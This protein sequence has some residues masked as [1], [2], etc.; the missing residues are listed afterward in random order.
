MKKY[1][2]ICF[3]AALAFAGCDNDE[4]KAPAVS[5]DA[6][7]TF[8]DTRDGQVYPYAKYGDLEWMTINLR[9]KPG[10][11][12]CLPELV[13]QDDYDDPKN[14]EYY[15]EFG[16][17]YSYEAAEAAVPEGW[18]IPTDEDW[19]KLETVF[20][21][22]RSELGRKGERGTYTG[23]LMLQGDSGSGFNFGLGGYAI[24][25]SASTSLQ[26]TLNQEKATGLYWSST[27]DEEKLPG[28]SHFY[29]QIRYNS[30]KVIRHSM[31][32]DQK[33]LSVRCVRDAR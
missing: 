19:Q 26:Y 15:A 27:P 16:F 31:A 18:R 4:V 21:M 13:P 24:P 12:D 25:N 14:H 6:T 3:A 22:K 20:G 11:G 8:T 5:P 10:V 32:V 17:L 33:Y 28:K 7:G 2:I 23:E 1:I 29:R 30:R 9:Y